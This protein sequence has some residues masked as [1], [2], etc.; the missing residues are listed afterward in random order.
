MKF[1]HKLRIKN[2]GHQRNVMARNHGENTQITGIK[3]VAGIC[4]H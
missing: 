4:K 3:I 2:R 1:E